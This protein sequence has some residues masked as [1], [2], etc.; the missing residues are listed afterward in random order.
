M[1]AIVMPPVVDD[2]GSGMTGTVLDNAF[3]TAWAT[4]IN[5]MGAGGSAV[6]NGTGSI[7]ALP[8]PGGGGNQVVFMNNASL[9]TIHGITAG[10]AGQRVTIVATNAQVNLAHLSGS[11]G[12][13]V[14][15]LLNRVTSAPTSLAGGFGAATYIY[16][17]L[18]M[19]G[20]RLETHEQG[21]WITAAYAASNFTGSGSMTWTVEA[22][23]V[24]N[25]RYYLRGR[26]LSIVFALD[27]TTVGGTP[28]TDLRIGNGAWGGY[29]IAGQFNMPLSFVLD[30]NVQATPGSQIQTA[31]TY[32]RLL[33][34]GFANWTLSTNTTSAYGQMLVG[35]S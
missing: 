11:A 14:M 7:T 12:S 25:C 18:T 20:W 15:R 30:N 21:D 10:V 35:V 3:F 9:A 28:S 23:D 16:D 24:T 29:T 34:S 4:A 33:K 26:Q 22:G 17:S 6:H 31:G 2:D 19:N 32:L 8:L 1:P 5:A 13:T 27:G